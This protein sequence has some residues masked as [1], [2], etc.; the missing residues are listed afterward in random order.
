MYNTDRFSSQDF[1]KSITHLV[2][3]SKTTKGFDA[4]YTTSDELDGNSDSNRLEEIN[5]QRQSRIMELR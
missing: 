5:L 4:H 2:P 3:V 1:S